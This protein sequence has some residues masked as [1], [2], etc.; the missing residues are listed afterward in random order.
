MKKMK[1]KFLKVSCYNIDIKGEHMKACDI[2]ELNPSSDFDA[3]NNTYK[4]KTKE[5]II[6]FELYK[7]YQIILITC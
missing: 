2:I 4:H 1:I 6:N 3:N 5:N 7:K